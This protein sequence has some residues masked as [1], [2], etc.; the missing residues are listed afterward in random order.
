[1]RRVLTI[2]A[3]KH[4]AFIPAL[5]THHSGGTN[6]ARTL[7]NG[8][9]LGGADPRERYFLG[10][11]FARDLRLI[12]VRTYKDLYGTY[13]PRSYRYPE[14]TF[15]N[16]LTIARL[17]AATPQVRVYAMRTARSIALSDRRRTR[18]SEDD[19]RRLDP[20]LVKTVPDGAT[21]YLPLYVSEL[22]AMVVLAAARR[23]RLRRGPEDFVRLD[24]MGG[25]WD[26]P[27]FAPCCAS[28]HAASGRPE[29]KK[30]R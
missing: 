26:D 19:V 2:L 17:M 29:P 22:A 7:V 20:A 5:S 8:E 3:T 23:R 21:L 14:M 24:E 13:G 1:M 28:L 4:G 11:Q 27:S 9:R 16:T 10:A 12:D 30:A 18:L 6:V 15:G 25:Q